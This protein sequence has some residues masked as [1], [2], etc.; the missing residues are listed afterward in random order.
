MPIIGCIGTGI[1]VS[2]GPPLPTPDR[3]RST[4]VD[5]NSYIPMLI[6]SNIIKELTMDTMTTHFITIYRLSTLI[7]LRYSRHDEYF[8]IPSKPDRPPPGNG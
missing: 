5:P 6:P 8:S 1:P 2:L 7:S 3:S 4:P